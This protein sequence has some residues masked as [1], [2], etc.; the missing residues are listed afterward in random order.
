MALRSVDCRCVV[1]RAGARADATLECANGQ[2]ACAFD[3][4]HF[5]LGRRD[6]DQRPRVRPGDRARLEGARERRQ[7]IELRRDARGA[8]QLARR[9]SDVFARVVAEPG[10][11]EPVVPFQAE[12][13]RRDPTEH[14]PTRRLLAREHAEIFIE[15]QRAVVTLEVAQHLARR[16]REVFRRDAPRDLVGDDSARLNEGAKI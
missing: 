15:E 8:L 2:L 7:R 6:V 11:R 14:A 13:R 12:K 5:I 3:P 16:P 9:D 4:R 1:A 10:K